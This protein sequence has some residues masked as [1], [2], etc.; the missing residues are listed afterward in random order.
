MKEDK[1]FRILIFNRKDEYHPYTGGAEVHIHEIARRWIK[2]GHEVIMFCGNYP[3]AEKYDNINGMKIIRGGNDYTAY[4]HAAKA[5][6]TKLRKKCDVII[7][8]INGVPFFT[9]LY[10]KKPKIVI[11]HHVFRN[12]FFIELPLRF[13]IMGYL[14]E[15]LIPFIYFNTKFI[16]V[17]DSTKKELLRLGIREKNIHVFYNGIDHTIYKPHSKSKFP[18]VIYLGRLQKYKRVDL[19]IKAFFYIKKIIPKARLSIA[20]FGP[21][22]ELKNLVEELNLTSSVRIYGH[23]SNEKK[24]KLL[25]NAW[26]FITTSEREGWGLSVLEANACGTPAVAF[27]VP[28]LRNSIKNDET[29]ILVKNEDIKGIVKA[30]VKI[31][32]NDNLRSRLSKNCI[33][34]S[35]KFDWDKT[36]NE[37]LA[38]IKQSTD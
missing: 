27:D 36:A 14:A 8:D 26:V 12:I 31:L 15:K 23:V 18:H 32:K 2:Q 10:V 9:P 19:V 29:G 33:E 34:W 25:Q 24:I 28:G 13:A 1:K 17:S 3:G 38:I 11:L 6:L 37:I 20:G 22:K 7:D 21:E 5:Y 30:V 16:T 4:F 35:K